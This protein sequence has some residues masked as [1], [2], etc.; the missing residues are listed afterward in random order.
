MEGGN[1]N[2]AERGEIDTTI[3]SITLNPDANF[4]FDP[5]AGKEEND[6]SVLQLGAEITID[7][8]HDIQVLENTNNGTWY[9]IPFE[10]VQNVVPDVS[11][12][13]KDG[14]LWVNEQGVGTIDRS[15]PEE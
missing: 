2:G 1:S 15:Q 4:R 10:H 7:A 5:Y 3:E 13:D 11:N 14:L 6:N 8:N 9:G 12:T